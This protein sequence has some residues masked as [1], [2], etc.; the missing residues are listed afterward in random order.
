MKIWIVL[1]LII[2]FSSAVVA[3]SASKERIYL[4]LG[5]TIITENG[6][7]VFL[8]KVGSLLQ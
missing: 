8:R 2:L 4:Q 5:N 1:T 6:E 3:Q 7:S